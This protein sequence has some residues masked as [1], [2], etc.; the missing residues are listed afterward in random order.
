VR[1]KRL[2]GI[3]SGVDLVDFVEARSGE[4]AIRTFVRANGLT[5]EEA[6]EVGAIPADK[7][8]DN[9]YVPGWLI[10]ALEYDPEM[11]F[12]PE[13]SAPREW[14]EYRAARDYLGANGVRLSDVVDW[15]RVD[16][17]LNLWSPVVM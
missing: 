1:E 10:S 6:E 17:I 7:I 15:V 4:E 9:V 2:W 11:A 13:E 14:E 8:R 12:G 5:P 16:S 3:V